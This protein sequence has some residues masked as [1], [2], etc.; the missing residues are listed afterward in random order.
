MKKTYEMVLAYAKIFDLPEEIHGA[1]GDLDRGDKNSTQKWLRDLSKNPVASVEAYFTS[2]DDVQDLMDTQ[3][4]DNVVVNPQT[5]EES[6]RIKDGDAGLGI[7]KFIKLKRKLV[8]TVEFVD[9]KT[10]SLKE[11]DKGGPPSVKIYD[12]T[13][14]APVY[15]PY[16]YEAL[17]APSTGTKSK[18]RFEVYGKG[19]TRLEAF[20]IT[21]L[22]E[23]IPQDDVDPEDDF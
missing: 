21:E 13:G 4:F 22:V 16:D 18:V 2:E 1:P 20:G 17:G 6:T 19:N 12:D 10:G 3:G 5:G 8:D 23:Y 11:V 7:G 14:E 15:T 9:R